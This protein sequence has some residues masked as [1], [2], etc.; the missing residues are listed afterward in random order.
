[1]KAGSIL[2]MA[3]PLALALALAPTLAAAQYKCVAADGSTTFQQV[4]C[5]AAHEE[6]RLNIAVPPAPDDERPEHIQRALRLREIALGMT[7]AELDRVMRTLPDQ[8]NTSL[9][10]GGRDDQLVYYQS[11]RTL[12]VNTRNGI[13]SSV[14]AQDGPTP[15][16]WAN[17]PRPQ[18]VARQCPTAS[19]IRSLE[20][21]QSMI[22]NRDN[23]RLQAE[24]ARQI[25][26]A[27]ACRRGE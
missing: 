8:T 9:H 25:G 10:D 2:A 14:Q 4:P 23:D 27:K 15:V 16:D 3:A 5:A 24:L 19:E 7:R 18:R 13:V 22:R 1:M 26:D 12:V 6:E 20:I 11:G 21:E 17:R